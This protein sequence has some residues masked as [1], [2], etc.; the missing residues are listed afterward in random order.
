MS[1]NIVPPITSIPVSGDFSIPQ[2][3]DPQVVLP[4]SPAPQKFP[5]LVAFLLI[6]LSVFAAIV[7][8]LFFQVRSMTLDRNTPSPTSTPIAS[9]DPTT[10]WQAYDLKELGISF[11]YPPNLQPMDYPNGL[12]SNGQKGKQLCLKFIPFETGF[13]LVKQVHAGGGA[14][15]GTFAIGSTSIDYEEGREGGFGDYH[16]YRR[17]GDKYYATFVGGTESEIDSADV[18]EITNPSG[19]KILL[20]T[21]ANS[22]QFS[23][24]GSEPKPGNPGEGYMGALINM[25][26]SPY[27]G[28]NLQMKLTSTLTKELFNQILSTFKFTSTSTAKPSLSTSPLPKLTYSLP[29]GWTKL[30][31]PTGKF[32]IAYDPTN[33]Q[34]FEGG[35]EGLNL[36]RKSLNS[37]GIGYTSYLGIQYLPYSGGSKHSFIYQAIN[38]GEAPQKQDLSDTYFEKEYSYNG[39]TCLFLNGIYISQYPSIWGMCDSGDGQAFLVT[40]Y[41]PDPK[42]YLQTVQTIKLAK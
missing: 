41:D 30:A 2:G 25:N 42:V 5:F 38:R 8:Y 1:E 40:S 9:I 39:K 33:T 36:T 22:I 29:T 34:L 6:L 23:E 14:C 7:I 35:A 31:D 32:E 26:K 21:G 11:K 13:N 15:G 20:V 28:F 24:R 4:V 37:N 3:S 10:D 17:D 19:I 18:K 12:E 16:G 27:V